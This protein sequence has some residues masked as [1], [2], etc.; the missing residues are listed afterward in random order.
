MA[1]LVATSRRVAFSS[2]FSSSFARSPT[3]HFSSPPHYGLWLDGQWV[4]SSFSNSIEKVTN[5]A[6]GEV[7]ATVASGGA[8]DV[9]DAV[10]RAQKAFESGEWSEMPPRARCRILMKA[11][12][13]LRKSLPELAEVETK[14][15][16][17]CLREYKA[18]LGRVPE[19]L[20]YQAAY[21]AA[22]GFE[23][24]L[25]PLVDG[26]DHVNLVW[27]VPLGVCGLITPWNHPLLIATKK[28]AVALAAGNTM[29]VKPPLEAP[30]TVL[31]LAEILHEAG[32]PAG[33]VQVI[34]G[35]GPTAGDALARHPQVERLDFTGGTATGLNIQR[36]MADAGRVRAYCA[37]LG[38]NAPILVFADARS[39]NEAVNGVAFAAFVAS[40]QTCVSAK[41]ILVQREV[42]QE[43]QEKLVAKVKKLRLGNPALPETDIGPVISKIQ[44]ER[45]ED[46]V[47]RAVAQGAEVLCGG[48]RPDASSFDLA[49]VGHFY[50]PTVLTSV[51]PENPAFAEEIFGPVISL[52]EFASEE[53]GV[54]LANNSQYGLGAGMW[55]SDV[56]RAHRV[57]KRLRSGLIWVNCHHRNDPSSPWGGFGQSGI[58]RENGPEAFD[59]YTTTQSLTIRSSESQENWFGD[60][61]ARY[62]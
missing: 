11:A 44:L 60:A 39:V 43:F 42:R 59:E 62:S 47:N 26:S 52:T 38:G 35:P 32:V 2:A 31:R 4:T 13:L 17:R 48:R 3:R 54:K 30:L 56:R 25:P 28:I 19:W 58:G 23:G 6:T 18:Q 61:N 29:V 8:A 45:I 9:D 21:A 5:P 55:T 22:K 15:T 1:S 14:Q 37:E 10:L 20:E 27:R 51:S 36:S 50:E 40:G 12:E 24:R 57:S 33:T 16:G 34:P 53:E 49:S 46:Q 7:V 41:R